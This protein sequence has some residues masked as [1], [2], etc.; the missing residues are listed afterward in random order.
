MI[1]T[2]GRVVSAKNP[3]PP[4]GAWVFQDVPCYIP[5][6]RVLREGGYEAVDSMIYYGQPG[7]FAEDVEESVFAAVGRVMKRVGKN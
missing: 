3:G 4:G 6:L 1:T 5:S 2:P 7:P